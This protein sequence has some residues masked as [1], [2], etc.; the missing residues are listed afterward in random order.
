VAHGV[1]N[2]LAHCALVG[3]RRPV[4]TGHLDLHRGCTPICWSIAPVFGA[5]RADR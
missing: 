1:A 3:G 4:S 5:T 2:E